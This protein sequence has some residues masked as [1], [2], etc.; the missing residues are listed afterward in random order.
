[1][2]TLVVLAHPDLQKS[3]VNKALKESIHHK[4]VVFS[5]L[6]H[7]YPDFKI[8]IAAEQQLLTQATHISFSNSPSFGT[9]ALPCLK[10][11]WTMCSPMALPMVQAARHCR[12]KHFL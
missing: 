2:A 3:R 9:P 12:A 8:D 7:K 4:G 5:E 6:Y 11:I 10:S 1:M